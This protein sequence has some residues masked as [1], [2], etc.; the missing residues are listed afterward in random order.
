MYK[1]LIR[2]LTKKKLGGG[3]GV[4]KEKKMKAKTRTNAKLK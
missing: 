2:L 4:R 1:K 3:G